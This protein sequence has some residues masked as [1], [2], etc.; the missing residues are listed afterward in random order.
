MK[1]EPMAVVVTRPRPG[2]AKG[3][4]VAGIDPRYMRVAHV[5]DLAE[6][7]AL[8]DDWKRGDFSFNTGRIVNF[9]ADTPP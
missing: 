2:G 8:R 7:W 1:D 9:D 5:C 3:Y 6:A 4:V